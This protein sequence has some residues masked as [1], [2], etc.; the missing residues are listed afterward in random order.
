MAVSAADVTAEIAQ[1]IA[2]DL[3]L[4]IHR[5]ATWQIKGERSLN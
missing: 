1:D 3:E 2:T 5:I 4:F